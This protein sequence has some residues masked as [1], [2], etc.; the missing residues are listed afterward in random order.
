MARAMLARILGHF[1]FIIGGLVLAL[2]IGFFIQ[3][4]DTLSA[5]GVPKIN[6]LMI[7]LGGFCLSAFGLVLL[8]LSIR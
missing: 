7:L 3:S 2:G 1:E 6:G 4:V 5:R 8:W